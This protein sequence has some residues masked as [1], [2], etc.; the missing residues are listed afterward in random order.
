M[1]DILKSIEICAKK[2]AT[3]LKYADF[4]YADTKNS[5]GDTKAT[6]KIKTE[7]KSGIKKLDINM[8]K[9]N[10]DG[11]ITKL[12]TSKSNKIEVVK[13]EPIKNIKKE[14]LSNSKIAIQSFKNE[15]AGAPTVQKYFS[16]NI[17]YIINGNMLTT[18]SSDFLKT[19]SLKVYNDLVKDIMNPNSLNRAELN[20]RLVLAIH[21][22][23][24]HGN[25]DFRQQDNGLVGI[26]SASKPYKHLGYAFPQDLNIEE[27]VR[28]KLIGITTPAVNIRRTNLNLSDIIDIAEGKFAELVEAKSTNGFYRFF[29]RSG[30]IAK[31]FTEVIAVNC[32][33]M[34]V[35]IHEFY[36]KHKARDDKEREGSNT[37][38]QQN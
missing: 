2:I 4:G 29:D 38:G 34:N 10:I 9:L 32:A 3:E 27:A 12:S 23:L 7:T 25:I 16:T 35:R 8:E 15:L 30:Y 1:K 21:D 37:N 20:N 22:A 13:K 33:V 36:K 26:W 11:T 18:W 19:K 17:N 31:E 28:V 6:Y 14:D 24:K 5:T